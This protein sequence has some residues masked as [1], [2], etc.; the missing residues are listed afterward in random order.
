LIRAINLLQ[1]ELQVLATINMWQTNLV[2]NYM[3]VLDDKSYAIDVPSRRA[4]FPF[5]RLLLQSCR[6]NLAI[7]RE[8][9]DDLLR[10]CGPLS[11]QT[12]QSLEIY[13]EDHGKAITAFTVVVFCHIVLW[14]EHRRY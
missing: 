2:Q 13:E 11:D 8:E 6:E 9:Y 1:E 12:K 14:H 10:R 3:R 4:M 7:A 5:E